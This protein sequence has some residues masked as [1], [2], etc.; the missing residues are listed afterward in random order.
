VRPDPQKVSAIE[1]FPTPTTAEQLKTFCG[2][3]SYYRRFI[4]NCSRIVSPLYKILKNDAKFVWTEAQENAFQ[5]LKSKQINR[6][7]LQYPDLSG[8]HFNNRRQ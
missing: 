6:P 8:V 1:Q 5:H 3:I 2:M 7:I 4:P